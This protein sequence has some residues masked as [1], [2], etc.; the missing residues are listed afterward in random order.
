MEKLELGKY[1]VVE[2]VDEKGLESGSYIFLFERGSKITVKVIPF[3][4]CPPDFEPELS[5]DF[6]DL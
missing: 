2:T 3:S 4:I 6:I 5:L 1:K